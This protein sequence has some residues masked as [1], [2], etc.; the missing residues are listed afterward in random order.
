MEAQ[1][2]G[3]RVIQDLGRGRLRLVFC[4]DS[5]DYSAPVDSLRLISGG[6]DARKFTSYLYL[7]FSQLVA[8]ASYD[9]ADVRPRSVRST[10]AGSRRRPLV[11]LV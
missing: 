4:P 9:E 2:W 5:L 7:R 10:F 11:T 8:A 3:A 6:L 1:K